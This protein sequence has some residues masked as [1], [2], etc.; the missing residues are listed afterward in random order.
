VDA[1]RRPLVVRRSNGI[2]R[3]DERRS[4]KGEDDEKR[5]ERERL[6]IL[7]EKGDSY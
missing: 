3:F 1:R 7:T 6:L 2:W 4:M 5:T